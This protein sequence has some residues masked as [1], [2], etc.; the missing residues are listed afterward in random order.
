MELNTR[1]PASK[2]RTFHGKI[3]EVDLLA[4]PNIIAFGVVPPGRFSIKRVGAATV[5]AEAAAVFNKR[6]TIK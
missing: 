5:G 2:G 3:G 6:A 4:A 1:K